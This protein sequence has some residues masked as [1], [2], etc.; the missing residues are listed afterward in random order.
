MGS[1]EYFGKPAKVNKSVAG[2]GSVSA[3]D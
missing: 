1:L 3:G 2:I